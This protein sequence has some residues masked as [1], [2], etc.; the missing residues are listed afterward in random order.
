MIHLATNT[1][2]TKPKQKERKHGVSYWKTKAWHEFSV[3]VRRRDCLKTSGDPT[4]G[5]CYT[6]GAHKP[7][8]G[9]VGCMQAGHFIPGR[10]GAYLFDERQVHAQC[11]YCNGPLKGNWPRYYEAMVKDY[12]QELV[13]ELISKK[14]ETK[15][16]KAFELEEIYNKYKSLN[17]V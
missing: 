1:M 15:D 11:Y 17:K 7:G 3:F 6:C 16:F 10:R 9:K 12:G 13:E 14:W 2:K 4:H 5:F 8:F